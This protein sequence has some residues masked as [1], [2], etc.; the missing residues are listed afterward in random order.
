MADKI[1]MYPHNACVGT[2]LTTTRNVTELIDKVRYQNT[3]PN[4]Y[5]CVISFQLLALSDSV[6]VQI[7]EGEVQTINKNWQITFNDN[8]KITSCKI[9]TKGAEII[10]SGI[11]L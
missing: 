3:F 8:V 11:L 2:R 10:W 7:N 4:S 9:L 5:P 6:E 1:Y